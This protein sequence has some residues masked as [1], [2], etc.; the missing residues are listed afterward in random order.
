MRASR[1][2]TMN[3]TPG[4]RRLRLATPARLL[5]AAMGLFSCT[6]VSET[7]VKDR[8]V[9]DDGAPNPSVV[10]EASDSSVTATGW[11][12]APPDRGHLGVLAEAYV[13]PV[14]TPQ[15]PWAKESIHPIRWEI[16]TDLGELD[17]AVTLE[18]SYDSGATWTFVSD[19]YTAGKRT[20]WT[21]PNGS[22]THGRARIVFHRTDSAGNATILRTLETPDIPFSPS[23]RRDYVW[24]RTTAAA[25]FGPRDGAGGIVYGGKM[26]LIGGWNGDRF[27]LT[28]A[29]DVWSSEDGAAW[30]QVKPNTFLDAATFDS[31]ADWEGRHFAGYHAFGGKM[32]I[33][34][35]D[36]VQG[37]YQ[38]DVWSSVDGVH[39][40]R[41]D[42]HTTTPRVDAYGAPYP[43]SEWRPVEEAQFGLR[44]LPITAVFRNSLFVM[45]GQLVEGIVDRDWPGRPGRGF[46]DVWTSS[47]GATF[48]NVPTTGP[49]WSPRGFVSEAVEH[50]G[51]MWVV[52]GGLHEDPA[53]GLPERVYH[54]DVWHSSDARTWEQ[55]PDEAPFV[56]RIWHNV[57][58]Y[59]G[60]IWVING[61]DGGP[62]GGGR[63][64]DNHADVWYSSDGSNWY[65][66]SPPPAFPGRH[67]GTAWVHRGA[68][69]VGSGN[70]MGDD[71]NGMGKWFADVWKLMPAAPITGN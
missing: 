60:R 43:A 24:T 2:T 33:V 29:N 4:A 63:I 26:W 59:D 9:V 44:S 64:A 48:T 47:N 5:V 50:D 53:A 10:K 58:E 34:G 41:T 6:S 40:T 30:T 8:S 12:G 56:P 71:V 55:A 68:L 21:V 38:S 13:P 35:G 51:R 62:L 28:C 39:W 45:G 36:P 25:P 65:E 16:P 46:N 22:E 32:W 69:F 54:N 31:T 42:V 49:M 19:D 27:P 23:Q 1:L 11:R 57:K 14:S 18:A 52:G 67:A 61:Y 17:I 3:E 70:A 20:L 15:A 37:Y 7:T 66:A